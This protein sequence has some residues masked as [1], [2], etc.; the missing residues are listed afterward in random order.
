MT[1]KSTV[2]KRP[3]KRAE[4]GMPP[5]IASSGETEQRRSEEEVND[6][7][8]IN[9]FGEEDGNDDITLRVNNNQSLEQVQVERA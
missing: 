5:K 3:I 7:L 2:D 1:P 9:G 6:E 8:Q 4:T